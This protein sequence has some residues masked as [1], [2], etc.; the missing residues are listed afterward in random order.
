M[1]YAPECPVCGAVVYKSHECKGR[2]ARMPWVNKP[3]DF[4][5]RVDRARA[6]AAREQLAIDLDGDK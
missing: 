2:R 4:A 3:T 5:A 1:S 6:A